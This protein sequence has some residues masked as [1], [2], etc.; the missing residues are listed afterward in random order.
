MSSLTATAQSISLARGWRRI[1]LALSA[2]ALSAL[3]MP[4]VNFIPI[5]FVTFPCLVWMLSG[6]RRLRGAFFVGWLFM[7]AYFTCGLYWISFA[8][9]TDAEKFGWLVPFAALVLPAVLALFY[10]IAAAA[11]RAAA[12][13]G[14][15]GVI[16][17]ALLFFL[18]ELARGTSFSGFPWNLFGYGWSGLWPVMQ[19]A[20]V[21]GIYGLTLITLLLC[22]LPAL[23]AQKNVLHFTL[24]A[25]I[26]LPLIIFGCWGSWRLLD[27]PNDTVLDVRLRIVQPNQGQVLRLDAARREQNFGEL[28]QL[29]AQKNDLFAPTHIIW[30]ETATQYML[31]QDRTRQSQ[32]AQALPPGAVLLTGTVR[33]QQNGGQA[34]YFNSLAA[35]GPDGDTMA[36]Y[37]KSHLVPFGEYVPLRAIPAIAAAAG[38]IGDFAAGPGRRTMRV[39]GLPPFSPLIC[40]EVIFPGAVTGAGGRPAFLLNVTNDAWYGDTSGPRQHLA[41]ARVRAVEEGLPL[42]RAANTG[43]SAVVDAYGN[44]VGSLPLNTAGVIDSALPAPIAP[45]WFSRHG[46]ATV[47]AMFLALLGIGLMMRREG[48]RA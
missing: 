38:G 18:A 32:I 41:I 16:L 6:T 19:L 22:A 43:I 11:W 42:I 33:L 2:G 36:T 23:L 20:S 7:F 39:A 37:D 9:L 47:A 21:T 24:A 45:T 44:I 1:L 4:P 27:V 26:A 8:L 46:I 3:A 12:W 17:F 35:I 31:A 34:D 28:L 30:P 15:A 14:P 5:L 40:Y 29:S 25:T 13:R 10:G 48:N